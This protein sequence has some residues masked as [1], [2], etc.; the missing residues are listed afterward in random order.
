MERWVKR[1]H[2]HESKDNKWI[3]INTKWWLSYTTATK[4]YIYNSEII[5][6]EYDALCSVKVNLGQEENIS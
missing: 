6:H 2:E 1:I 3:K 4:F 5:L